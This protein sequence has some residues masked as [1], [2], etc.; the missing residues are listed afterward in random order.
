MAEASEGFVEHHALPATEV[1]FGSGFSSHKYQSL[2][3]AGRLEHFTNAGLSRYL[4]EFAG[5][6]QDGSTEH[7]VSKVQPTEVCPAF[8]DTLEASCRQL[9]A[10]VFP[11][12]PGPEVVAEGDVQDRAA[13]AIDAGHVDAA[14]EDIPDDEH[15]ASDDAVFEDLPPDLDDES[16]ANHVGD[17]AFECVD[18]DPKIDPTASLDV[19]PLLHIMDNCTDALGAIMPSYDTSTHPPP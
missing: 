8:A 15:I 6:I 5:T 14:F 4:H 13:D 9:V 7:R 11:E 17:A 16:R 1:G 19:P 18:L 12:G 2:A 3:H 10:A